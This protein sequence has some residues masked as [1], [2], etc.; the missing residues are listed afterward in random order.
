MSRTG[1]FKGSDSVFASTF[2]PP[3]GQSLAEYKPLQSLLD[4]RG[5]GQ[6]FMPPLD[7]GDFLYMPSVLP[8]GS[9]NTVMDVMSKQDAQFAQIP[10]VS[11]GS[12]RFSLFRSAS[13]NF[14][15]YFPGSATNVSMHGGQQK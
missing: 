4:S 3:T 11:S 5:I 13:G 2:T 12:A 1:L 8:A 14:A 7:E 15:R 10:E 9:I 6:E